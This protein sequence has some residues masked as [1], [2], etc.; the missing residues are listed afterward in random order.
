[1]LKGYT[2]GSRDQ[3]KVRNLTKYLYKRKTAAC[4]H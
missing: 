3:D 4:K 2:N 1:M